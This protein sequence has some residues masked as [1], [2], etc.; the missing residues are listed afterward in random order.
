MG[1][2][3]WANNKTVLESAE[4][5]LVVNRAKTANNNHFFQELK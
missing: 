3:S 4:T 2:V 1:S 5:V